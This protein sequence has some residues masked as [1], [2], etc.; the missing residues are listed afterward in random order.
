MRDPIASDAHELESLREGLTRPLREISAKYFYDDRGSALFE[1]ITELDEYYPTR[2][3]VSILERVAPFVMRAS[4]AAQIIELGSGAG[5]KIR[6]LLDAWRPVDG[7]VC[8][9]LD[10]NESFLQRSIDVLS[11]SYPA[12]RFRGV[13]G[14]FTRDLDKL[15][16][17]PS[18]RL[19][20]FFAGTIGNLYPHERAEFFATL[21][22]SMSERD[23]LLLGVDLVKD[24]ARVELAYNDRQGVTAEFNRN[25]LRV[26]NERYGANFAPEAF[27]HRAFFDR[28]ERWIEM[29][30][31]ATRA[32]TVSVPAVHLTIELREGEEIRTEISCKFTDESLRADLARA[33]LIAREVHTDPARDFA[34][35]HIFKSRS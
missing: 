33:G 13:L 8:T 3:E 21:A 14:D 2:T 9:M 17:T 6:L 7:G 19:T 30:L 27:E 16:W 4:D 34:L 25:A 24:I 23:S 32:M 15:P 10:V 28:D 31:R 1:R 35:A 12:L 29:R 26:I 5:R 20:V 18:P 22:R 11:A